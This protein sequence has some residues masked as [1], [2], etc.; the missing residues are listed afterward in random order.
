MHAA[1]LVEQKL[2]WPV[3]VGILV[4]YEAHISIT[5]ETKVSKENEC[6]HHSKLLDHIYAG[7][8]STYYVSNSYLG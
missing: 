2:I 5:R 7:M 6:M 3:C 8:V 4:A 1:M